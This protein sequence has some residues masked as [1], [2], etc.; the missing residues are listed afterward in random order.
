MFTFKNYRLSDINSSG[1]ILDLLYQIFKATLN[2]ALT[3]REFRSYYFSQYPDEMDITLLYRGDTLAGF[4]SAAFYPRR[5]NGK[6]IVICRSAVGLLKG[7]EKGRFPLG[8]LFAGFM[9]YKIARPLTPLY[10]TGF[11]ANPI[12]YAMI[13]KYTRTVYPRRNHPAPAHILLFKQSLLEAMGLSKKEIAPFVLQIHFQVQFSKED[14]ARFEASSNED[15]Q[16]YLRI[17]PGYLQQTGVMVLL[18]V[19]WTNILF[20]CIRH[21][22]SLLLKKQKHWLAQ[23]K[24][25]A[26][27]PP[28]QYQHR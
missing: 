7:I 28:V 10:I 18:P 22:Y 17:N 5:M 1:H 23:W 6:K 19:T 3:Q 13:C 12:M 24:G 21:L 14:I 9:R 26:Q 16:Y 25:P 20:T 11:M 8:K 27:K 15:V 4:F 2:P